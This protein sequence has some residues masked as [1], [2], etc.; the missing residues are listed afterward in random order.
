MKTRR[1]MKFTYYLKNIHVPIHL[2]PR[3][4]QAGNPMDNSWL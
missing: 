3:L 4:T 1:P 2:K